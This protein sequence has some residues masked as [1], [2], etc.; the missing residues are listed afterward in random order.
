MPRG[1]YPIA[2]RLGGYY[3][4]KH[5]KNCDHLI[6]NTPDL[7]RH[8]TDSGW[9]VAGVTFIPNFPRVDTDVPASRA[10]LDTPEGVPVALVLARLHPNKAVDVLIEAL[11]SVPDLWVWIAGE[12][13]ERTKLEQRVRELKLAGRVKFL[14]WRT[15]RA[16][17]FGAADL[18]VF[19]SREEPF[20]NVIVEAWAYGVPVV[21]A[22][23][24]GPKWLVRNGEDGLL[25][26]VNDPAALA[27]GIKA[28]LADREWADRLVTS[29]RRRASE[30][31][32]ED[33]ILAKYIELMERL[34]ESR[35]TRCAG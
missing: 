18:C 6:C 2:G 23:A 28:V 4:L 20:G 10:A 29:G 21:A 7:V 33:A 24:T 11:P 1:D 3:N 14:G 16:A 19:P 12:G 34:V 26:P 35:R 22:A 17:L 25:V 13:E 5:F 8:V 27:D 30:G 9:P 32:S 15:D 31:F